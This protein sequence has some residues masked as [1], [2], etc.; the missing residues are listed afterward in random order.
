M[1]A[2]PDGMF[3]QMCS[4]PS[5]RPSRRP[6]PFHFLPPQVHPNSEGNTESWGESGSSDA[7]V[8]TLY[9]SDNPD[10]DTSPQPPPTTPPYP[11]AAPPAAHF[12]LLN[13]VLSDPLPQRPSTARSPSTEASLPS[14]PIPGTPTSLAQTAAQGETHLYCKPLPGLPLRRNPSVTSFALS[15]TSTKSEP[16]GIGE[17]HTSRGRL[18]LEHQ[19]ARAVSPQESNKGPVSVGFLGPLPR[20]VAKEV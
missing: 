20:P 19:A 8:S 9:A 16:V 12:P 2:M 7:V 14:P 18:W 11:Y 6:A 10:Y 15:I 5:S 17:R 13:H 1:P 4:P 3:E